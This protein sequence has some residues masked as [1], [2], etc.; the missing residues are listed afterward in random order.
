MTIKERLGK[1]L[2]EPGFPQV[3]QRP[4]VRLVL[5]VNPFGKLEHVHGSSPRS[6]VL[7]PEGQWASCSMPPASV[8]SDSRDTRH[9]LVA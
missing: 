7:D 3:E 5:P 9:S 6:R 2:A 1:L 8:G 4:K